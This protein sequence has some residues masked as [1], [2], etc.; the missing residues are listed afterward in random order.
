M[1]SRY[2]STFPLG[3]IADRI[4]TDRNDRLET[5]DRQQGR[6]VTRAEIQKATDLLESA[7]GVAV[8][9]PARVASSVSVNFMY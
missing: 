4:E 1:P 6:L 8:A 7:W 9:I 5:Q 2:A 3:D